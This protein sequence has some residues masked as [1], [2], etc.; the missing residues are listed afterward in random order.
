M[1]ANSISI[2]IRRRIFAEEIQAVANLQSTAVVDALATVPRERFLPPGPWTIRSEGDFMAPARQTPDADPKHVHHNL[3]VA[4]DAGRTLFNGAPTVVAGAIDA[5]SVGLGSRVLHIGTGLGYY[6]ALL[7]ECVGPKGRVLGI[8][9]SHELAARAKDNL[10]DRPW[11]EVRYGDAAAPFDEAFDTILVNAGVTHPL[12][13]WLDALAPG[14]RMIVPVTATMGPMTT[15]GKGPMLLLTATDDPTRL[16]ARTAG[17]VAIYSAVGVRSDAAN[18][19]IGQALSKMPF[20]PVKS[21]RRDP[22]QPDD[23]CWLHLD[24]GCVSLK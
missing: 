1:S 24:E 12:A 22:H 17:F 21:F 8:E 18:P 16:A 15:I 7:A 20:A 14:G 11:V 3:A 4:I 19:R 9:V 2:E 10:A 5:L 6:T 13:S 23:T